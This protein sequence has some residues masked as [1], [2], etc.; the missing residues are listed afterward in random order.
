MTQSEHGMTESIRLIPQSRKG[1]LSLIFHHENA[2]SE[3]V[4]GD[5][6]RIQFKKITGEG[7]IDRQVVRRHLEHDINGHLLCKSRHQLDLCLEALKF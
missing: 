5:G 4:A 2:G 6:A 7:D 3:E 1:L